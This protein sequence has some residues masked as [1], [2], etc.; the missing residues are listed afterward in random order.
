MLKQPHRFSADSAMHNSSRLTFWDQVD[1]E[2]LAVCT[3]SASLYQGSSCYCILIVSNPLKHRH[4]LLCTTYSQLP[5]APDVSSVIDPS[6]SLLSLEEIVP[7][8][9]L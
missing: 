6:P 1:E 4:S 7:P 8:L 5:S 3:S 9:M 2:I